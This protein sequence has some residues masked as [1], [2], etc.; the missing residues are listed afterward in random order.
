MSLVL[1]D[2][3][4]KSLRT[5][6]LAAPEEKFGSTSLPRTVTVHEAATGSRDSRQHRVGP[7]SSK[8]VVERHGLST[9]T[10]P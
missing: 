7:I 2:L 8:T 6:D 10:I 5:N 4:V 9:S 3:P 1:K